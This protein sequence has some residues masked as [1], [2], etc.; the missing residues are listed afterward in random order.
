MLGSMALIADV[1][2]PIPQWLTPNSR[3]A[4]NPML[5]PD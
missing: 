4:F 5:P 1:L 2:M 3:A